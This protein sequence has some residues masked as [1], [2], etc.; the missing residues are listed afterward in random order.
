MQEWEYKTL[1]AELRQGPGSLLME[2]SALSSRFSELGR[3]GWEMVGLASVQGDKGE[4][5]GIFSVFK[6]PKE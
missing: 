2:E 6:R 4:T 5:L 1:R 3:A